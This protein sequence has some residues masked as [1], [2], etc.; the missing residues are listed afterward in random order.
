MLF[1]DGLKSFVVILLI[2][3]PND[4]DFTYSLAFVGRKLFD[5]SNQFLD[6]RRV[7]EMQEYTEAK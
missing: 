4:V 2:S 1:Y 7:V 5:V 6:G 3:I